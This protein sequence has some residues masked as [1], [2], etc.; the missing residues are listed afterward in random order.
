MRATKIVATLGPSTDSE[1]ILRRLFDSG[2]EVFRLNAF[3][4]SHDEHAKR[5][6]Q[7]VRKLATEYKV[8]CR[9]FA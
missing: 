1:Q 7:A 3:H 8:P 5:S 9:R 4:C 2:V 6:I